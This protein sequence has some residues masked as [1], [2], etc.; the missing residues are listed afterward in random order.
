M[1]SP[2]QFLPERKPIQAVEV[3]CE[4]R[5]MLHESLLAPFFRKLE[6]RDALTDAEHEAL[7]ACAAAL[8]DY[9]AGA[10]LVC[11]GDRPDHS[12]LVVTGFATRYR[13]LSEGQRQ[14]TAI[15]VPGDFVD[16]HSF[17]L[18]EMDHSVGALSACRVVQFPHRALTGITENWPHLTR[19][20]WL[21]T[22]LDGAIFREWIVAMGRRS[23]VE[24]MAH[25]ICELDTRLDIVGLA[26]D[27]S[28]TLPATQNDL[29]DALGLSAV[30]INRVLQELRG[31][32]LISWQGQTVEILDWPALQTRAEFDPRYLHLT[33]EPR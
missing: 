17:P 5:P 14:I 16:L 20:L 2:L 26:H 19:M 25:L 4:D 33:R 32:K 13:V 28:F 12:T 8:V 6:C 31:E 29:G 27:H 3:H 10:D 9:P 24:Q 23:A 30:H 18:K 21:M 11:E 1:L 7:A 22:L 15:H